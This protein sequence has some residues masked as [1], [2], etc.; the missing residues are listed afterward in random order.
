LWDRR[1]RLA[2]VDE[3]YGQE[4][5]AAV[6]QLQLKHRPTMRGIIANVAVFI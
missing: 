4:T 2:R 5:A 1:Q 6:K 3:V